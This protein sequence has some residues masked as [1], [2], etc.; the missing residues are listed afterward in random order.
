MIV[1]VLVAVTVTGQPLQI[2][3]RLTFTTFGPV[4]LGMTPG[5]VGHALG[6]S[7]VEEPSATKDCQQSYL[8]RD[9]GVSFM[10]EGGRLTR[11]DITDAHHQTAAGLRIGDMEARAMDTYRGK[12]E[13]SKHKYVEGGKYLTV[14]SRDKRFALVIETDGHYVTALRAGQVP[15]VEYVEGCS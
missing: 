5:Q 6:A 4:R 14:R 7:L 11:I 3:F 9:P 15:S 12:V 2:G 13:V 10:F 1:L 8:A